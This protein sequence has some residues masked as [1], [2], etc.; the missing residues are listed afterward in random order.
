MFL[1]FLGYM[2]IIPD[3]YRGT[4][5]NPMTAG[6]DQIMEFVKTN[7]QWQGNLKLDWEEKV[8]PYALKHGA[9]TF[10][11]IGKL[12]I[13]LL[14]RLSIARWFSTRFYLVGPTKV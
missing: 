14:L 5:L 2:V 1:I 13:I 6:Q 7:T 12:N 3:Y 4:M 11:A 10:G 9:K 8:Q